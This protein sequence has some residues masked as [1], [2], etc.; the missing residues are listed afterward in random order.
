MKRIILLVMALAI[1]ATPALAVQPAYLPDSDQGGGQKSLDQDVPR[2][3]NQEVGGD[4]TPDGTPTAPVPEPGTI[5]L[6][7][8]SAAALGAAARRRRN[9]K[10]NQ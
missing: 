9:N 2:G 4:L 8:M 5:A 7:A 3:H 6:A 10:K 1:S